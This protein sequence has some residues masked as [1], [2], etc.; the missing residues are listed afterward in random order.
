VDVGENLKAMWADFDAARPSLDLDNP[1]IHG[2]SP[3]L[4]LL[5]IRRELFGWWY[6]LRNL[7]IRPL[8]YAPLPPDDP[9]ERYLCAALTQRI[10]NY[11]I[12]RRMGINNPEIALKMN[13]IEFLGYAVYLPG[14]IGYHSW[15]GFYLSG[16]D[17][18]KDAIYMD[19]WWNQ[20]WDDDASKFD[21]GYKKQFTK[22]T[23]TAIVMATELVLIG[24]AIYGAVQLR[25]GLFLNVPT[26][27]DVLFWLKNI[28]RDIARWLAIILTG[29]QFVL[30]I[31]RNLEWKGC[32]DGESRYENNNELRLFE[33]YKNEL[34]GKPLPPINTEPW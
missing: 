31:D 16:S 29:E 4:W 19:P 24:R 26:F 34:L 33:Y 7:F 28:V 9:W 14:G 21:Y 6:D 17:P 8:L 12:P 11:F 22:F 20:K 2:A 3:F 15:A 1:E 30:S 18:L 27:E 32:F 23:L 5:S 13:G 10:L 25:Q